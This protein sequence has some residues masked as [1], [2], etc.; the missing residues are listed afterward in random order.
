MTA[1]W[2]NAEHY[3]D[4]TPYLAIK[5][6]ERENCMLPKKGEIWL[7]DTN[8]AER[9]A[10]IIAAHEKYCSVLL[11]QD[12]Q[13][14]EKQVTVIAKSVMYAEPA[15]ISYAFNS[16]FIAPVKSMPESDFADL[17]GRVAD[18]LCIKADE[19][20][21]KAEEYQKQ[22]AMCKAECEALGRENSKLKAELESHEQPLLVS[23]DVAMATMAAERDVYKT[24]Y[25]ETLAKLI[26]GR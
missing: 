8:G 5:N 16:R 22:L 23:S 13:R 15:M 6:I 2:R 19:Q 9:S 26:D 20:T 10:V 25:T 7:L 1:P 18:A 11:L 3:M 17:L 4:L 12:E 14:S 21:D 24:L